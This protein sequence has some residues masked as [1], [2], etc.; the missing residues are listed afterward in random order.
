M[1]EHPG[2]HGFHTV[3]VKIHVAQHVFADLAYR[4][5]ANGSQGTLFG[6]WDVFLGN[7]AVDLGRAADMD[8]GID[9]AD[10]YCFQ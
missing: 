2:P 5:G 8:N 7:L 4:I 3:G 9:P 6:Y 10:P 1:C